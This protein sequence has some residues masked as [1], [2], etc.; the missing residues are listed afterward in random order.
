L[1]FSTA[2]NP[3]RTLARIAQHLWSGH[4]EDGGCLRTALPLGG[5][6][7]AFESAIRRC[8][9]FDLRF[10]WIGELSAFYELGRFEHCLTQ[11]PPGM[12]QTLAFFCIE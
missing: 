6:D 9:F 4:L 2:F 1:N 3:G 12:R 8:R 11:S 7:S 5:S 10:D